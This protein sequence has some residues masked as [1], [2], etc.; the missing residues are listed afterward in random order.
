MN[1]FAELAARSASIRKS[2][3]ERADALGRRLE[4]LPTLADMT[5]AKHEKL[6]DDHENGIQ[7]LEDALRDLVG[8]N[9]APLD[10][11]SKGSAFV[12]HEEGTVQ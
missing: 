1:K 11:T 5:F 12:T 4:A 9:G 10:D 6:L 2:L 8:H 3:D 7:A